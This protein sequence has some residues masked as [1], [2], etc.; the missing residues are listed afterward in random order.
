MVARW[1]YLDTGQFVVD[2]KKGNY[3]ATF[4]DSITHGGGGI[5]DSPANWEFSFQTYLNFPVVNLRSGDTSETLLDRFERDV[6]P[7]NPKY[8]TI[9]GGT[10]N[11]RAGTPATKVIE[12]PSQIVTS[13]WLD[14]IR[15]IFLT[16]PP[17]NPSGIMRAFEEETVANWRTEFDTVNLFIKKQRYYIDLDPQLSDENKELPDYY[18][19]D[20]MHPDIEGKKLMAQIINASWARV[21]R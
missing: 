19:L 8:L 14:G 2:L 20:G 9:L 7:F 12:R 11:S 5:S 18:G 16:L 21:T 6:L 4:G 10:N 17:I 3:A 13:A 15:P 1:E